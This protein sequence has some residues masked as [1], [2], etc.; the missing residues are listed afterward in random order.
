MVRHPKG[1]ASLNSAI[2][3]RS[4]QDKKGFSLKLKSHFVSSSTA[5]VGVDVPVP[6]SEKL[7]VSIFG[8]FVSISIVT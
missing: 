1:V 6:A 7:R 5:A 8:G 4:S 3:D 2:E